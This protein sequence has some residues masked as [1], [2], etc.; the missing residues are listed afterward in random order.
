MRCYMVFLALLSLVV[1]V[2]ANAQTTMTTDL[3][4]ANLIPTSDPYCGS[5][6]GD[7]AT[8]NLCSTTQVTVNGFPQDVVDWVL[9]D[10]WGVQNSDA[11]AS[12]VQEDIASACLVRQPALLLSNGRIVDPILYTSNNT[13][14]TT[15]NCGAISGVSTSTA[16]P[17]LVVSSPKVTQAQGSSSLHLVIRH[18]NHLT[19]LSSVGAAATATNTSVDDVISFYYDFNG[20]TAAFGGTLPG[21][22]QAAGGGVYAMY[23]GDANGDGEVKVSDYTRDIAG[24]FTNSNGYSIVDVNLDGVVNVEDYTEAVRGAV[25]AS[26]VVGN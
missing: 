16:C 9:V 7:C 19:V 20:E 25:G 23:G 14:G 15:S 3:R 21:G 13:V 2:G 18:R 6:T 24:A 12:L 1:H 11:L 26:T 4:S 22:Q 8:S 5:T 17:G 10:I